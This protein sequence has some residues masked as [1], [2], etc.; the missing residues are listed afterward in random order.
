MDGSRIQFT[1]AEWASEMTMARQIVRECQEKIGTDYIIHI[2]WSTRMTASMGNARTVPMGLH[3]IKL[4]KPLWPKATA[5][6]RRNTVIHEAAHILANMRAGGRSQGH[7]RMWKVM[8]MLLGGKPKRTHSVDRENILARR[9]A[10]RQPRKS[11]ERRIVNCPGCGMD[12]QVG[13][14]QYRRMLRGAGYRH[15]RCGAV[16]QAG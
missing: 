6:E 8:M 10:N 11:R 1:R 9:Q 5:A 4:S 12:V 3:R 13:P 7:G 15:Q 16:L 14:I 2:E